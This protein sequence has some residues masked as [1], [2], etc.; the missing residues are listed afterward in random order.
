VEEQ[1]VVLL[2]DRESHVA[3]E[4]VGNELAESE[5]R[6]GSGVVRVHLVREVLQVGQVQSLGVA[7]L[8]LY[9]GLAQVLVDHNLVARAVLLEFSALAQEQVETL[10]NAL[11]ILTDRSK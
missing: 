11:A 4:G 10:L 6:V 9:E 5:G 2:I 1:F 8:N 3:L 7:Q